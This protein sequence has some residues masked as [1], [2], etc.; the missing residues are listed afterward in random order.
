MLAV[1]SEVG[2]RVD[3]DEDITVQASVFKVDETGEWSDDFSRIGDGELVWQ[4][5][6][7]DQLCDSGASTHMTPS[8][9]HMT[10]YKEFNLKLSIDDD[11][12][13]SI[14]AH[15]DISF[16]FRSGNSLVDLLLTNVAH[17]PDLRH[18]VSPLPTLK[19]V[20]PG[21][22]RPLRPFETNRSPWLPRLQHHRWQV[23][24]VCDP[25]R[26]RPC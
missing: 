7:E 23:P 8:A 3:V 18:H 26:T 20:L 1:A 4:V 21:R 12:T 14:E 15:S 6:D 17:G 25:A 22:R 5:G 16:V 11:T 9:D 2:G 10:S 24:N 13:R 19:N